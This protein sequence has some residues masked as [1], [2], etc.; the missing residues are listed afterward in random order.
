MS[1]LLEIPAQLALILHLAAGG[2]A[3]PHGDARLAAAQTKFGV[4]GFGLTEDRWLDVLHLHGAATGHGQLAARIFRTRSGLVYVPVAHDR[5][6]LLA[7]A[8][9]P[10]VL[11]NVTREA[12]SANAVW[13]RAELGRSPSA[14]ELYLA[15]IATRHE[16]QALIAAQGPQLV[17]AASELAPVAALAHRSLFFAGTR[18]LT[19]AEVQRHVEL[20]LLRAESGQQHAASVVMA[21]ADKPAIT[22]KWR[23]DVVRHDRR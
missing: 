17:R 5:A 16:A 1:S 3:L 19:V 12:A 9:D 15:H 4:Q 2:T 21:D 8:K 6:L 7:R 23:T 20:A 14:A 13:L 11:L 10:V 22:V 18:A